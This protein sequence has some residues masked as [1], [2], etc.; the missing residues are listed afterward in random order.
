MSL[1][2]SNLSRLA[3]VEGLTVRSIKEEGKRIPKGTEVRW[4][5]DPET[6]THIVASEPFKDVDGNVCVKV[7]GDHVGEQNVK[8]ACFLLPVEK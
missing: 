4:Y 7:T 8:Y 3:E 6:I 2:K 1:S 5:N